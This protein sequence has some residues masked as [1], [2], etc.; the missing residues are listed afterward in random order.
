ME[1]RVVDAA[2]IGAVGSDADRVEHD[3]VVALVIEGVVG[4]AEALLEELLAVER[5]VLGNA[6]RRIDAADIVI[7]DRVIQLQAEILL[8]LV[9]EIKQL[10]RTLFRHGEANQRRGLRR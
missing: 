9:V 6:A 5:I 2:L 7:A 3:E 10:E 1:L 4:L 8:R